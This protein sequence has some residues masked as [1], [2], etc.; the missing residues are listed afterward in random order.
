MVRGE[1]LRSTS[2]KPRNSSASLSFT[3]RAVVRPVAFRLLRLFDLISVLTRAAVLAFE[4]RRRI[5]RDQLVTRENE[6]RIDAVARRLVNR[7]AAEVAI[8][9]VFIV[10]VKAEV[11]LFAVRRK[12]LVFVQHDQLRRAPRLA[13]PPDVA[14]K[15]K[16]LFVIAS[17]DEVITRR[18][19]L[20][21]LKRGEPGLL[22]AFRHRLA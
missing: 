8:E 22:N 18:L 7:V 15:V 14:P 17:P 1:A 4:N 20:N 21:S 9:L 10:V 6:F 11:Y 3:G 2:R 5:G 12:F 13:G 19:R 16:I